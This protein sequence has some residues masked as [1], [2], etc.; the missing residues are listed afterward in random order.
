MSKLGKN[1]INSFKN[2]SGDAKLTRTA[3]IESVGNHIQGVDLLVQLC[4][5]AGSFNHVILSWFPNDETDIEEHKIRILAHAICNAL[6][7]YGSSFVLFGG[8]VDNW[9]YLTTMTLIAKLSQKF[10]KEKYLSWRDSRPRK[11]GQE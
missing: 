4:K 1:A 6:L 10:S 5:Q 2:I 9:I 3:K 7:M 8:T 11:Y